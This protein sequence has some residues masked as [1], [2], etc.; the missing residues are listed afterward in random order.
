M[1]DQGS[2]K[3][4]LQAFFASCPDMLFVAG[5]DGSLQQVSG[6]LRR[7]LGPAAAP[8]ATLASLVDEADREPLA[9]A[10]SRL[11]QSA[12]PLRL[13]LR[14]RDA[15]G[16]E[17]ALTCSAT[18]SPDGDAIYGSLQSAP[19]PEASRSLKERILDQVVAHL[20]IALWAVDRE[21]RFGYQEG[22]ALE[23]LGLTPHQCDGVSLFEAQE[24][25]ELAGEVKRALAGEPIHTCDEV[26][27]AHWDSWVVPLRGG[28]GEIEGAVGVAL[29]ISPAKSAE[30]ELRSRLRQIEKQQEVIRNLSTPIIEVWSGVLT[31]PMVGI[32]DSVRTADVM[33]S[34]LQ[35][36]VEQQAR[37]AILDLTGVEMVDT[38]V[39][40]HLIELVTA[41][42][43]LG[44]EGIV[45]GI[46]PNVAQ[47]MVALGLDLSQ[48]VT[49]RNLRAAL[50]YCIRKMNPPQLTPSP[51][52]AL[53]SAKQSSATAER[54]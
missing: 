34:V 52:P 10:W 16:A 32:V 48:I 37:F 47:T 51:S 22:R 50:S 13:A 17:Q 1:A 25:S 27:G 3:D 7:A 12:E 46:K 40:S 19:A 15:R 53:V 49:Q 54:G 21:G 30:E 9:A 35:R 43:L 38:R 41:I 23:K 18:Q 45:A 20:P 44:A 14:F 36:I 26:Q 4:S 29:D 39:A 11:Q 2:S 8:G 24:G 31:L 33:D 42:R 28:G 6:A 5:R